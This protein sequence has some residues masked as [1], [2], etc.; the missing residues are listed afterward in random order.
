MRVLPT[1]FQP[2]WK[3][4]WAAYKSQ[5]ESGFLWTVYHKAIAVNVWRKQI[6]PRISDDCDTCPSEIPEIVLHC[7][8]EC[9]KACLKLR[10]DG[11]VLVLAGS[12]APATVL[13]WQQCL[14][15]QQL[16]RR[17]QPAQRIW[18]VVRGSVAWLNRLDRNAGVTDLGG[19]C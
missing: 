17:L 3:K 14:E 9:P 10:T 2:D 8:V 16:A 15:G 19:P 7:L 4:L 18:S 1:S 12:E 6:C 11:A 5:K 13:N